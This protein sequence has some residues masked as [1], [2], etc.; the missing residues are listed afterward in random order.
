MEEFEATCECMQGIGLT[1]E[2]RGELFRVLVTL[3]CR[4]R[5]VTR[6][7]FLILSSRPLSCTLATSTLKDR[8][9]DAGPLRHLLKP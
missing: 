5:S 2:S 9:M 1:D 4:V 7:T 8:M 6:E 3:P